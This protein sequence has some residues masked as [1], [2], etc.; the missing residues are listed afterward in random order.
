MDGYWNIKS[1]AWLISIHCPGCRAASWCGCLGDPEPVD[2]SCGC[3]G[4]LGWR[5]GGAL[6]GGIFTPHNGDIRAESDWPQVSLRFNFV[7]FY[8]VSKLTFQNLFQM[9][10]AI[11]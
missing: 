7:Q 2:I 8:L 1:K 6:Y 10:Q 9:T 4:G 5:L 11:N 3:G